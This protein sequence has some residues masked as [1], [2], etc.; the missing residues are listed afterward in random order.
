VVNGDHD[1]VYTPPFG[2]ARETALAARV[3]AGAYLH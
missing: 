2:L 3:Y 1:R